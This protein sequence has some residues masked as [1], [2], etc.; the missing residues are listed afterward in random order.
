MFFFFPDYTIPY[1]MSTDNT[2]I[3]LADLLHCLLE[4][5]EKA[6]RIARCF[7]SQDELFDILV[8]EKSDIEKNRRRIQDFK[9][10]ADVLVQ[11]TIKRDV[12]R[13]VRIHKKKNFRVIPV[14]MKQISL[15]IFLG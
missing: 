1:P 5:S 8:E 13:K 15:Q 10:L 11:E 2:N 7:R 3:L 9:T 14:T 12:G 4:C 6:A